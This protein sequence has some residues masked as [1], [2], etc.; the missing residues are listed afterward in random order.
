MG[1]FTWEVKLGLIAAAIVIVTA[2]AGRLYWTETTKWFN[3][4]WSAALTQVEKQNK[5]AN[6]EIS[7]ATKR[8]VDCDKRGGVWDT[9]IGVCGVAQ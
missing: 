3:K 9:T 6:T 8:V 2:M 7:D 4:G 5:E 1:I